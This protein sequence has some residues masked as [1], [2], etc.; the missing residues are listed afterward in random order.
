VRPDGVYFEQSLYYHI[1]A[2][3]FFL[4]A[5]VL[6]QHN[7]IR[8]PGDFDQILNRMLDVVAAVSQ[9]G[10]PDSFGDDDGGRVFNPRRNRSEHLTDPLA[11]GAILFDRDDLKNSATLTEEAVW[12]FGERASVGFCKP[13][14][15]SRKLKPVAFEAGGIYVMASSEPCPQ[16]MVIDAGPQGIGHSGHGHADALS[17]RVSLDGH[18]FL[19]DPG[20]FCYICGDRNKFR[21]TAAHNTLRVDELDQADPEGPFA[22]SS[23]PEIRAERW[24]TASTFT[25]FIGSHTGYSRLPDPVIHRRLIFHLKGGDLHGGFW[26]VQDIAAG[27]GTHQL[28]IFWHFASDI[29]IR[30]VEKGFIAEPDRRNQSTRPS[31]ALALLAAKDAA[32]NNE[33]ISDF[34][35][36]AYGKKEPAP[37]VCMSA[38]VPLPASYATILKPLPEGSGDNGTLNRISDAGSAVHVYRY[39]ED[40]S[41]GTHLMI[42]NNGE[43]DWTTGRWSS[44]ARFIY[45]RMQNQQLNHLILSDGSYL[46]MNEQFVLRH[47]QKIAR[48]EW[49]NRAGV[50]NIFSSDNSAEKA[51]S[52]EVAASCD[53]VF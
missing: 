21:G 35:S 51:F 52:I 10:P 31:V 25:L 7:G 50:A 46:Q 18:R 28:D 45:L 44:D 15:S 3:D 42:F 34:V 4:H 38:K 16:Q 13:D 48:F 6:A 41:G 49:I 23:L 19:I 1:Y 43:N 53:S 39:D 12:L 33:L 40:E 20:A 37:V 29:N 47:P 24:V 11:I 14:D 8:V 30:P 27:C 5:R 32:W 17:V 2:L 9:T 36:L 26:F 22:W